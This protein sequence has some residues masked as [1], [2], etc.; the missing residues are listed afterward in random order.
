MNKQLTH[1]S[2]TR[3]LC[4]AS[5][6]V[7]MASLAGS[8]AQAQSILLTAPPTGQFVRTTA[9]YPTGDSGG[10]ITGP[11]TVAAGTVAT[12]GTNVTFTAENPS[13]DSFES[14]TN[15]DGSL[16]FPIN[17]VEVDTFAGGD[18]STH[19]PTG[20]LLIN[21]SSGVSAFGLNVESARD[22]TATFSFTAYDGAAVIGQYTLAPVTQTEPDSNHHS[23]F[24][25]AQ[26][27]DGNQITS[28]VISDVSNA[29]GYLGGTNDFYS[30][31]LS[32]YSPVPEASTTVSFGLL[33]TL[34]LGGMIARRKMGKTQ[35]ATS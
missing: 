3:S 4:L 17:S 27:T 14:F 2:H 8:A 19:T 15:F 32:T 26:A 16:D 9:A 20:P 23:I 1:F 6:V 34:G 35:A 5:A 22:D 33:L 24:L 7:L 21:F 28:V 29:N 18:G 12:G 11:F 30:G 31:P 10:F 25:G 13:T